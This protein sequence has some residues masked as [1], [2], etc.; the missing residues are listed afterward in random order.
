MAVDVGKV[1]VGVAICDSSRT[2][3][4]PVDTLTRKNREYDGQWFRKLLKVE[5]PVGFVLGLPISPD[6]TEND[7][8]RICREFGDW[9]RTLTGLPVVYWD[10]RCTSA[11]A[12]SMLW[13]AGL[14]HAQ[15]KARQDQVAAL[16]FL[17]SYLDA[18]RLLHPP[19]EPEPVPELPND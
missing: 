9:L 3:V 16:L 1:R 15:R 6:R 10:E 11:A 7:Q 12:E 13:D 5:Q 17:Q 4:S 14:T 18:Q 8:C 2:I 19:P